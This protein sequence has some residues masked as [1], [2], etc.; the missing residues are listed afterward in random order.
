M[1]L[2][3]YSFESLVHPSTEMNC[4]NGVRESS[5]PINGVVFCVCEMFWVDS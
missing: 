4:L 3:L 2:S 5:S 1:P